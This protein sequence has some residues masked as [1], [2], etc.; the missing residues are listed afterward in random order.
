M[1][2]W[3]ITVALFCIL[4]AVFG[5]LEAV[6]VTPPVES[7]VGELSFWRIVCALF[8][9]AL[10]IKY[11]CQL[12]VCKT[13]FC[14]S[15]LFMT[16]ESNIAYLCGA[17]SENLINNW[18]LLLYTILICIGLSLIL[19]KRKGKWTVSTDHHEN[20]LGSRTIYIDCTT[21]TDRYVENNLGSTVIHFENADTYTGGG[22]LNVEN[23]LG[24]TVV[25]VPESW[26]VDCQIENNLGSVQNR[27]HGGEGPTLTVRGENNLGSTVIQ[28]G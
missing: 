9:V 13:L 20:S 19:P 26:T 7:V 3:K 27:A 23:N 28:R 15:L 17:T 14:L 10:V 16:V 24:S 6:G 4:F 2:V 11:L 8:L 21:F 18:L 12:R 1:K 22:F 5:L 25:K